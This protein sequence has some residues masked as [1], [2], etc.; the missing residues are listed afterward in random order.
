M[1][2]LYVFYYLFLLLTIISGI[3][4]IREILFRFVDVLNKK[5]YVHSGI[6]IRVFTVCFALQFILNK[7]I[8]H[9]NL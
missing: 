9:L 7:I 1:V 2:T 4:E 6:A 3:L 8:Y 5:V